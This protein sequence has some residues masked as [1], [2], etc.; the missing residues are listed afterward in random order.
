MAIINNAQD[1]SQIRLLCIIDRFLNRRGDKFIMQEDL[2]EYLR[3]SA[4]PNSATGADRL[5]DNLTFWL[6]EGLWKQTEA[7]IS[8][9]SPFSAESNLPSRVLRTLIDN[10]TDETLLNETRGQPF[11]LSVT[12]LLA[13]DKFTFVGK[14]ILTKETV[15]GAV[16][17]IL[18]DSNNEGLRRQLNLSNEASTFLEFAFFL[19]FVEPFMDG[20]LVD[21]TRA[22]EGVLDRVLENRGSLP[23]I[24]FIS[25]LAEVLPMIDGGSYRQKVEPLITADNWTPKEPLHLSASLSQ[26]LVRLELAMTLKYEIRADDHQA[27]LLTGPDGKNRRISTVSLG[28][29]LK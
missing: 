12:S 24:D 3:P 13:Q 18:K 22:I 19:G 23:A 27:L 5:P 4:L 20:Y 17:A 8:R 1:G 29:L 6:E 26:A 15:P 7:G 21:P 28:E 10:C 11:L 16:G 14:S 2:V 9:K 25:R